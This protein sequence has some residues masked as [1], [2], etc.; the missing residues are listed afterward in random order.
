MNVR[1]KPITSMMISMANAKSGLDMA[2]VATGCGL[3]S[4]QSGSGLKSVADGCLALA[5]ELTQA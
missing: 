4:E 5:Q 1:G 3:A 2:A